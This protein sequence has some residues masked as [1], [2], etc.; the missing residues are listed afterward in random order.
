MKYFISS[1][2]ISIG[3]I[4]YTNANAVVRYHQ[5][6]NTQEV[7]IRIEQE[8]TPKDLIEFKS[9]LKQLDESKKTLH[10]NSVVL[11]SHGGSGDTAKEIG[12]LIRARKLNTYL[13]SDSEC[14]SAC[15]HVLI[16][17]VQR[18]AFGDV[19]VHRATFMYDSDSD[20]HVE[21]FIKEA[22]K[23]N[24][25]YVRSMGISIMLAD[26]MDST[27]S[28][29][30]RQLTE[31]EK[32]QWQV[33][34]FDTLAEE[35]YFNQTARERHISRNEFI[36]IFKSNYEDCL[37][38][39][40]D[41]KQTVFDCAKSK[42]LKQPSYL[43][44]LM[45]WLDKKLDSYIGTDIENLPF[46][47]QVETLRKQIRDGKLYKRYTTITEVKDLKSR[48]QE[49]NQ[50]DAL[51]IQ[52]MEAANKWWVET[53]KNTLSVLVLNPMDSN[54]KV[55]IF[56]LST[57]DCKTDGGK[58]RLLSLQLL[59]NLEAKNSAIYS[60]QLPFNYNKAI[61]NGTRC[62]LIKAAFS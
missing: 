39:A 36:H 33:F 35:L 21:K 40:R 30:I 25:D 51:S 11:E 1:A 14:A 5:L 9:A 28:W 6:Q 27:V 49:L 12:N 43:M 16:S 62:G 32:T 7:T 22:K 50:I 55:V 47:D 23:S 37:K 17:G 41:F 26:A 58:K 57:T 15:V 38:E 19:R 54:L 2:I 60:G 13:A 10:M 44:Q 59:A 31:L 61:G 3:L 34:G 46:Q 42:N 56:E 4:S 20:D 8:I 52:K 29:S 18:Y 53:D 48:N 24:E 45:R